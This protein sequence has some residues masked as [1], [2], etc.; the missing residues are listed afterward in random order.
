MRFHDFVNCFSA[1]DV[2]IPE[3]MLV[4]NMNG[5]SLDVLDFAA[6]TRVARFGKRG[7]SA[8]LEHQ[9]GATLFA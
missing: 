2:T 5:E 1:L 6:L 4:R 3:A 7:I 8:K 9:E